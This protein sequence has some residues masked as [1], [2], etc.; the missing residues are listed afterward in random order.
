M[1]FIQKCINVY[2]DVTLETLMDHLK[3]ANYIS[4]YTDGST[5]Y[6]NNRRQSGIGVFLETTMNAT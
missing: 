4:I 2:G 3:N 6:K 5:Q 1:E